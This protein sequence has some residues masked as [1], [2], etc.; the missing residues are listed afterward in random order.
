MLRFGVL[1]ASSL[2]ARGAGGA[3]GTHA[4]YACADGGLGKRAG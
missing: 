3:T 2:V 4:A 1:V